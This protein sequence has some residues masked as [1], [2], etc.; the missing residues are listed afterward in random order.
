MTDTNQAARALIGVAK[1]VTME[2]IGKTK[3]TLVEA[4]Q[5]IA[6]ARIMIKTYEDLIALGKD[7]QR[8]EY[9]ARQ[10]EATEAEDYAQAKRFLALLESFYGPRTAN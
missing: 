1:G 8:V 10:K 3:I 5:V 9:L 2:A 6:S 7:G 4:E